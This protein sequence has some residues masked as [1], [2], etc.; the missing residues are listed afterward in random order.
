MDPQQLQ[1]AFDVFKATQIQ[2]GEPKKASKPRQQMLPLW[3]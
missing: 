3:L 1:A 2:A